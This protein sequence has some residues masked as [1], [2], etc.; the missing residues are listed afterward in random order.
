[1]RTT[2]GRL[3]RARFL[4]LCFLIGNSYS[5]LRNMKRGFLFVSDSW[6]ATRKRCA[7]YVRRRG[8]ALREQSAGNSRSTPMKG[9]TGLVALAIMFMTA[10]A[11]AT[12]LTVTDIKVAQ[13]Y[14]WNGLVD[15]T[16]TV[17]CDDPTKDVWVYPVGYDTDNDK[18]VAMMPAHLTG[19]GVGKA[20]KSGTHRMTWDMA[21]AMGK[22]YN[23]AAFSV[24]MH[25]FC[26]AAPY[27]VIDL[28]SGSESERYEVSYLTE[29]PEGGWG[30]EYLTT[31]MVFR[32][33]LPG[34]S[35]K[36][37]ADS[38]GSPSAY[39]ETV[40]NSPYYFAVFPMTYRQRDLIKG[41]TSTSTAFVGIP[42]KELR[43][44][45]LGFKWPTHQQVD[46]DSVCGR[47]RSRTGMTIDIPTYAQWYRAASADFMHASLE[48]P[49]SWG[50][51]GLDRDRLG[52]I[53]GDWGRELFTHYNANGK[54][55]IIMG[56]ELKSGQLL[57][58][59][60][61][62]YSISL[63]SGNTYTDSTNLYGYSNLRYCARLVVSPVSK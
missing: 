28:S 24:K 49:N 7:L 2:L 16:Y 47:M 20:V 19:D 32:L 46:A 37:T 13:R 51:M 53:A 39:E 43:G 11:H 31:K 62:F 54:F 60:N 40:V 42:Y 61:A 26:D 48:S 18:T 1:M 56:C 63:T 23:R 36:L 9:R 33:I 55:G 59:F 22:D 57:S 6:A 27:M 50:I 35:M 52:M 41:G 21:T 34:R 30:E 8:R 14:P 17:N 44:N 5:L 58:S 4:S 15:I 45:I 3:A 38:Y 25:A 29:E 10:V 12:S